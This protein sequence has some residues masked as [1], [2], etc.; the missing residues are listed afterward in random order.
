M[1]K[2]LYPARCPMC[3]EISEGICSKCAG[4]VEYAESPYCF[5]CGK[6]LEESEQ[7]YCFDCTQH[8]HMFDQGRGLFLYQEPV[9]GSIHRIKYQ[10]CR[11]YLE[12]YACE[13]AKKLG[14]DVL[15]WHPEVLLPIPMHPGKVRQRGY[16]QAEL[17]AE[18]LGDY[19]DIPVNGNVLKKV[20]RT[21]EQKALTH[22][23][24]RNNLKGAFE[25]NRDYLDEYGNLPWR[26]VLLTDDVYTTGS[27]MDAAAKVLKEHGVQQ[28]YFIT[29]C[30]GEGAS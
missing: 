16:N 19:L 20:R 12:Y 5:R 18:K 4:K 11:E 6:P 7:E 29:I 9:K 17:L 26:N 8:S 14:A 24:R 3:Q 27:T 10:N 30:V 1:I 22:Q 2:L 28:V 25:I 23:Q 21:K 15:R 13:M